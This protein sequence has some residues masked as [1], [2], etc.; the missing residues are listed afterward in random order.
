MR[1]IFFLFI[2]FFSVSVVPKSVEASEPSVI[3]VQS[4]ESIQTKCLDVVQA[5]DKCV[6]SPGIYN[7]SLILKNSGSILSPI[8]LVCETEKTC[9]INSGS[10]RTVETRNNTHYYTIDGMRFIGTANN[11]YGTLYFGQ[12]TV[13]SAS[14]KDLGNNGFIIRNCYVEGNLKFYGH[15][16]LVENCEF[17]GKNFW[18]NGVSDWYASSYNNTYRNNTIYGYPNRG[19]W[20]M[21]YT[22]NIII[23]GNKIYDSGKCIDTDGAGYPVTNHTIRNNTFINCDMEIRT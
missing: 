23:E 11:E 1:K 4:G 12:G 8:E 2:I 7:E 13:W 10:N 3:N 15:D 21:Q 20:S 19:I 14:Q 22:D 17:N 5:G 9:T 16:N 18:Q 6:I